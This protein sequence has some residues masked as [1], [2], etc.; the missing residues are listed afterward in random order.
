MNREKEIM[1]MK[2]HIRIVQVNQENAFGL[3]LEGKV[4]LSKLAATIAEE[5]YDEGYRKGEGSPV[6]TGYLG[7]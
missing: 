4:S 3:Y 5:L 2:A 1:E 6:T 7:F